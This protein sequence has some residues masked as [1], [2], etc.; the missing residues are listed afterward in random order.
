MAMTPQ[1]RVRAAEQ[2]VEELRS[3]FGAVG[4][5]LPSLRVDPVSCASAE[6]LPL[7]E[8][9]RCNLDTA[10]RLAAVLQQVRS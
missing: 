6:P 7:V 1:E 2:A 8:L 4:V 10:L 5:S 9:G 3:G